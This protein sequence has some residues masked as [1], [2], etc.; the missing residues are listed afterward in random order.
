MDDTLG[1]DALALAVETK[2]QYLLLY[3]LAAG[4]FRRNIL[5]HVET[6]GPNSSAGH[7]P[8][9]VLPVR[10]V[11][12]VNGPVGHALQAPVDAQ[13]PGLTVAVLSVPLVGLRPV[14]GLNSGLA[15]L[16]G[17]DV[18]RL[19]VCGLALHLLEHFYALGVE[20]SPLSA[21]LT[22]D[23]L[24]YRRLTFAFLFFFS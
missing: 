5:E 17:L 13:R 22:H 9:F 10:C 21:G 14:V 23:N 19:V 2:V 11:L 20:R 15:V 16:D 6:I 1:A 24:L 7:L 3:V 8:L 18:C 12:F 4:P